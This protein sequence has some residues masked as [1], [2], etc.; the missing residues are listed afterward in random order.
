MSVNSRAI[1]WQNK[2]FYLDGTVASDE[3][4]K[5]VW[6][7]DSIAYAVFGVSYLYSRVPTVVNLAVPGST[8]TDMIGRLSTIITEMNIGS[9]NLAAIWGGPYNGLAGQPDTVAAGNAAADAFFDDYITPLVA[10]IPAA[11]KVI[12]FN[13]MRRG[14][15]PAGYPQVAWA[16]CAARITADAPT[17]TGN[18]CIEV[19]E[20][21]GT[22]GDGRYYDVDSV[23]GAPLGYQWI[24]RNKAAPRFYAT[25]F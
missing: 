8:T 14:D 15:S 5:I 18:A 17:F 2:P 16:Q 25:R 7:G 24:Y 20:L 13:M 9:N 1:Y 10:G 6:E 12:I 11:A 22:P 3:I 21:P 23:H 19:T 4:Q